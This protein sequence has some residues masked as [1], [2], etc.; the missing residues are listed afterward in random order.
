MNES[1]SFKV[2]IFGDVYSLMSDQPEEH[3][4][5]ASQVVDQMMK[6]VVAGTGIQDTKR[7]AVLVALRLT[8][9]NLMNDAEINS[10]K[11]C[12]QALTQKIERI[13]ITL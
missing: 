9:T 1:K 12:Y 7:I 11:A 4:Y 10:H 2:S 5:E 8:S 13:L 6:E 3:L